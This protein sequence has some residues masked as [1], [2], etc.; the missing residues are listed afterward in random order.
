VALKAALVNNPPDDA[1]G[2][3]YR[4]IGRSKIVPQGICVVNPAGKVLDWVLMFDDDKSVL[5]FLDHALERFAKYPDAKKA[6]AAERY[7]RFPSQKVNDVEDN[8]EA[9]RVPDRHPKGQHCPA[10]PAL[11]EGTAVARLLG[12]ALDKSGKPVA[13]T[14]RQEHYVEDRFHVAVETQRKLAEALGDAG[15][16]RVRLPDEFTR[17]LVTHAYLGVLDV[18]PLS[19]PGGSQGELKRCQFWAR[20]VGSGKGSTLWRVEGES[21]VYNGE[22]MA[23]AGP[24][25]MHEVKLT[26]HG[27][28]EMSGKRMTRLVLSAHG[29]ERLR[30]GSA[31]DKDPNEVASLPAGRRIDLSCG[32]CYGIIAE[33]AA[34]D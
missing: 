33:P 6:V 1:E 23:N 28:I 16:E 19:N 12:R 11:P 3:L 26:W 22:R 34:P 10:A 21:A 17:E 27:F 8:G 13:D 18:Q 29:T 30:F 5:A 25:D 2:R 20:A 7:A 24:G 14:V 4:E 9:P 32:V 31:R 15:K